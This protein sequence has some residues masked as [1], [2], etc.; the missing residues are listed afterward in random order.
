MITGFR[1]FLFLSHPS[2]TYMKSHRESFTKE[3]F[4]RR[5][6]YG[7]IILP[8]YYEKY[9]HSWNKIVSIERPSG[10]WSIGVSGQRLTR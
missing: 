6:E 9:I 5:L 10:T 2:I 3:Q 8:A 4:A 7:H 1:M